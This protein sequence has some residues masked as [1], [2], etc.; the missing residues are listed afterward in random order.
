MWRTPGEGERIVQDGF[1]A[2]VDEQAL[3]LVQLGMDPVT[4]QWCAKA[5]GPEMGRCV[6][7]LYRSTPESQLVEWGRLLEEPGAGRRPGLVINA[8]E[9]LFTGGPEFA[10][11]AA[12]RF[13]AQEAVLAGLGHW[14]ML[15]EPKLAATTSKGFLETVG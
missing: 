1:E 3:N 6:L 14:W 8:T 13:G 11:R 7:A 9:D 10:H 4:A 2:P 12:Q 5:A 15:Q